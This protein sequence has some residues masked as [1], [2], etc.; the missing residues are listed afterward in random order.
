MNFSLKKLT[1]T[2]TAVSV[3]AG[4]YIGV[5]Q[6]NPNK[7]PAKNT[8]T[9]Y[10]DADADSYGDPNVKKNVAVIPSGWV[11]VNTDCNDTS[12]GVHPGATEVCNHIDDNCDGRIDEGYA[13]TKWYHDANGDGFG[14]DANDTLITTCNDQPPADYVSTLHPSAIVLSSTG[15]DVNP[16]LFG[17]SM[18]NCFINPGNGKWINVF[19]NPFYANV[20]ALN[21]QLL[22]DR[23]TQ[24][25]HYAKYKWPDSVMN[26]IT[27]HGGFNCDACA[28]E[29]TRC[30]ITYPSSVFSVL[31]A[32]ADSMNAS[33]IMQP[34]P[35]DTGIYAFKKCADFLNR[36][37]GGVIGVLEAQEFSDGWQECALC[38]DRDALA[39]TISY[40]N[41]IMQPLHPGWFFTVDYQGL[42]AASNPSTPNQYAQSMAGIAHATSVRMYVS[43]TKFVGMPTSGSIQACKDSMDKALTMLPQRISAVRAASELDVAI[44]SVY[45]DDVSPFG[46][47]VISSGTWL[48]PYWMARVYQ[49][50]MQ[51]DVTY[52]GGIEYCLFGRF[53]KL[54]ASS[55]YPNV[56]YKLMQMLSPIYTPGNVV[57]TV[58]LPYGTGIASVNPST[59]HGTLLV[60]NDTGNAFGIDYISDAGYYV[61]V[62]G[63]KSIWA[64]SIGASPTYQSTTTIPGY[65]VSTVTF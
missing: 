62:T 41:N 33:V 26:R 22:S 49:T 2:A 59:N 54:L 20:K 6:I 15:E 61:P 38:G 28:N 35:A 40:F 10:Q 52:P 27:G 64:N 50:F 12:A 16:Y 24:S 17:F 42:T 3:A 53:D 5:K 57:R 34:N 56:T 51:Y 4:A 31:A 7:K 18:E 23:G 14:D 1:L 30:C 36:K 32:F 21:P 25:P 44:T 47:R 58:T 11:E 43:E 8:I 55:Q 46:D 48:Q 9:V 60:I 45:N 29:A 39:D 65:S 13:T 37:T 19:A 63:I